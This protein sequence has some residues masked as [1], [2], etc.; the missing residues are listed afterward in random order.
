MNE[1][2]QITLYLRDSDDDETLHGSEAVCQRLFVPIVCPFNQLP[3]SGLE[4]W[5]DLLRD[6]NQSK[7]SLQT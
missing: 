3:Q 5:P 7:I 6:V 4:F 1:N 2:A